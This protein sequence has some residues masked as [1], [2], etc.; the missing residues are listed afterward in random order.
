M[1]ACNNNDQESDAPHPQA[2]HH[3][4]SQRDAMERKLRQENQFD[5]ICFSQSRGKRP[6]VS[7]RVILE[8]LKGI[9]YYTFGEFDRKMLVRELCQQLMVPLQTFVLSQATWVAITKFQRLG[10]LYTS[11]RISHGSG[12]WKSNTRRTACLDSGE[13]LLRHGRHLLLVSSHVE[14]ELMGSQDFL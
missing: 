8:K 13:I 10:D 9:I 12:H 6:K 1:S 3:E 5:H 2:W 4:I 11:K 7:I 14:S